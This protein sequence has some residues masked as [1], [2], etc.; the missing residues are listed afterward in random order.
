ME[1]R[2]EIIQKQLSKGKET[3]E[4][5]KRLREEGMSIVD[6]SNRLGISEATVRNS[7]K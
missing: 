5:I 4:T 2:K 7:I 1:S 6:I 3:R